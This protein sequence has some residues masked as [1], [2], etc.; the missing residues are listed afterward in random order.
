MIDLAENGGTGNI[1]LK[2]MAD[3]Q[4]ISLKYLETIMPHLTKAGFVTAVHGKGGGYALTRKPSEYSVGS[5][6]KTIEGSLS[7]VACLDDGYE[8][9][10]AAYCRTLPVWKKL[11]ALIDDY[12]ESVTLADLTE[13]RIVK[14]E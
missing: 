7:P 2:D 11:D 12:L 14:I 5:I 3:R 9:K 4:H 8:C 13:D 10:R 6:L 1:P